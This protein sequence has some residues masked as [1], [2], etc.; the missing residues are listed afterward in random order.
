MCTIRAPRGRHQRRSASWPAR[1]RRGA[2]AR[3]EGQRGPLPPPGPPRPWRASSRSTAAR[4]SL[5]GPLISARPRLAE[6]AR[7]LV[8]EGPRAAHMPNHVESSREKEE[9]EGI[10]GNGCFIQFSRECKRA[11]RV[12]LLRNMRSATARACVYRR[13]RRE[14][15]SARI[16]RSRQLALSTGAG[17]YSPGQW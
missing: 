6:E 10:L 5:I 12:S 8:P 4:A 2:H 1:G 17:A 11:R 14:A 15:C 7:V 16:R 13:R 3:P 9:E